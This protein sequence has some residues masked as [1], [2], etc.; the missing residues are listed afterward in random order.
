MAAVSRKVGVMRSVGEGF[1]VFQHPDAAKFVPGSVWNSGTPSSRNFEVLPFP[2]VIV[3]VEAA[4]QLI[5]VARLRRTP[6]TRASTS[7]TRTRESN[8]R[9]SGQM[10]D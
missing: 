6:R 7:S 4:A 5:Y 2:H 8:S 9:P 3:Q 10:T 1:Y